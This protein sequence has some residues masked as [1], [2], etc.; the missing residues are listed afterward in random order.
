[1][2]LL[3]KTVV[4]TGGGSGIGRAICIEMASEGGNIVAAGRTLSTLKETCEMLP[5][6]GLRHVPLV[7][8]VSVE[9]EVEKMVSFVAQ[10]YGRLDVMCANAGVVSMSPVVDLTEKEWDYIMDVNAKGVFF[11]CKHAARQMIR[12]G[13]RGKIINTASMAGKTGVATE[14]H[15]SA[16]KFAVI[17]FTQALADELA[18][19]GINVNAVCPGMVE[20]PMTVKEREWESKMKSISVEDL[21]RRSVEATPLGRLESPKDSAKLAVFLAS[22]DSDFIT[23]QAFNTSG[24]YEKH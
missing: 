19:Y 2:K 21:V 10:E 8:D 20:T 12:Q 7:V 14:A 16:S 5:T 13:G 6:N 1:M 15:Y 23:G 18:K 4:V 17:G 11:C 24:G 3:G 9:S 22:D